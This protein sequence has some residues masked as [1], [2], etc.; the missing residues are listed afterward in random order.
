MT[1]EVIEQVETPEIVSTETEPKT[2]ESPEV[3]DKTF[4]QAELDEILQRRLSKAERA[5]ERKH[6]QMLET[7]LEK[8]TQKAPEKAQEQRK[9]EPDPNQFTDYGEYL[10]AQARHE[11]ELVADEKIRKLREED[12]QRS[13]AEKRK[14]A[15]SNFQKQVKAVSA[16]YDDFEEVAFSQDVPVSE[17]M[18]EVIAESDVGAELAYYLGKNL[19]IA[20]RIAQLSPLAAARE[21]GKLEAKLSQQPSKET[22]APPPIEPV[23]QRGKVSEDPD[24]MSVEDWLKWRQ[25]QS[26]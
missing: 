4:T 8:V 23:G 12:S 17:A 2:P 3:K 26:K 6:R 22:K 19:E 1:D 21:I 11:A 10:K 24:K 16:K 13:Q 20:S 15:E 7:T 9:G 14:V 5:W 25:K 18:A